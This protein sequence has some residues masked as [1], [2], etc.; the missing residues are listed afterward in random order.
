MDNKAKT[1]ENRLRRMADRQGMK[2]RR[3][4]RRDT[5]AIDYGLYALTSHDTGGLLHPDGAN[6]IF[7][8][9]L[10]EVEAYLTN[11]RR[12]VRDGASALIAKLAHATGCTCARCAEAVDKDHQRANRE[13]VEF[14]VEDAKHLIS[15]LM[16]GLRAVPVLRSGIKSKAQ[17]KRLLDGLKQ[18]ERL[19]REVVEGWGD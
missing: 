18:V 7:V 11:G 9:D 17:A 15:C 1:H 3:S 14:A 13:R 10:I 2:L 12:I 16:P 5:G 8:L 19:A 6:T 4:P